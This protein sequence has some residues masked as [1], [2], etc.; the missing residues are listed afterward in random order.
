MKSSASCQTPEHVESPM[1]RALNEL[2]DDRAAIGAVAVLGL[3]IASAVLAPAIAPY[4]PLRVFPGASL[5]PPSAEHIMGT[6][7]I[8][9]D[10]FSRVIFGARMSLLVGTVSVS[11]SASIG[12]S[13]GLL[14][15]YFG[16]L[17]DDIISRVV[18][19]ML[20]FPGILL[21]LTVVS[22]LGPGLL[23]AMI[24]VGISGVPN[25]VRLVRGAVL[26]AKQEEYV[27]AAR[28]IGCSRGHIIFRH[29][30]PNVVDPI[31]VLAS[32]AYGWAILNG[33][34]LSFLG[35][36]AQPPKPEW[37][38]MLSQG[39][40]YLEQAYWLTLFPGTAIMLTVLSVNVLG[41]A[42]RDAFDPHLQ[43]LQ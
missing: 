2:L 21:A 26:S 27:I 34:S 10:L 19:M 5:Q 38:V 36:G 24:A 32:L 16:G 1:R 39:R 9:R 25:F 33:A 18:D 42:L 13:L 41:E 43:T 20:A 23:N 29:I 22:V 11:V 28:G 7:L 30:L 14:A 3:L 37:G 40:G 35:L 31:L 6:D 15:G 12:I 8:G 17:V 4:D